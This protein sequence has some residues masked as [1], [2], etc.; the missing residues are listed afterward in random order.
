M[1]IE[2]AVFGEDEAWNAEEAIA[3]FGARFKLTGETI[4]KAHELSL[5][6][7]DWVAKRVLPPAALAA[8]KA[9]KAQAW[10]AYEADTA[11]AWAA[12]EGDTAQAWDAYT[13]A[14]AQAWAAYEAAKA[15][16]LAQIVD[17]YLRDRPEGG[18][19]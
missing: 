9:A 14:T 7:A 12:Y 2:N 1:I 17:Q 4:M 11:Q 10:A 18:A 3:A 5:L 16:A 8:Y 13:A 6:D 19:A 15:P